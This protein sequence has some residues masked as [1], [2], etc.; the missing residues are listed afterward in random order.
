M[1]TQRI[2][3]S[4]EHAQVL[5]EENTSMHF[6]LEDDAVLDYFLP[7]LGDENSNSRVTVELKGKRSR[8]NSHIVFFGHGAQEQ[9]IHFEHVH[10]GQ[11]T[12]SSMSAKGAAKDKAVSSF[13][14]SV[15]MLPG[16]INAKGHLSEHNL[17][18]SPHARITAIPALEIE[19]NEV[20]ASHAATLERVDEEKMFYLNARGLPT[21]EA[22]ELL[23]EGFFEA[24]FS[25]LEDEELRRKLIA[26][27]FKK[28]A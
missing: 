7:I 20:E 14:G 3:K 25:S 26:E 22:M 24:A 17:I 28:L 21:A 6:V 16:S 9:K 19:H 5:G 11:D 18:L 13:F 1:T 2:L 23:V 27:L 15:K 12:E 8:V 10:L 4:G